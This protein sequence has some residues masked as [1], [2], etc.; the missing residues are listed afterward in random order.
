MRALSSPG[1]KERLPGAVIAL[2]L[3][4]GLFALL[5]HAFPRVRRT[6]EILTERIFY[7]PRI[8]PPPPPVIDARRPPR[9]TTAPSAA[10]G[11]P[12]PEIPSAPPPYTQ[13]AP[14]NPSLLRA[15]G[16]AVG[17]ERDD[18]GRPSPFGSCRG[19]RPAPRS[20]LAA[21]APERPVKREAELAAERARADTPLRVPCVSMQNNNLGF[22]LEEK[23]AMV[24]PLCALDELRK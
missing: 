5:L 21:L 19:V 10:P 13:A 16:R 17:C 4:A 14:G 6:P 1:W 9:P 12:A 11:L 2:G 20:E 22:G 3:Q 7:L 15:F 24:D 8:L 23:V 18:Q